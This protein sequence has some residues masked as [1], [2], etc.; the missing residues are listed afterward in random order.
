MKT[1][2]VNFYAGPGAGKTTGAWELA[3]Q[4][5]K[6]DVNV[7][8]VPEY[9]KE[10][11]W[12]E[13]WDLL[14]G[15]I[16]GQRNIFD[17]QRRRVDSIYGKVDVIVTDCP[18]TLSAV[19]LKEANSEFTKEVLKVY[20]QF[21]NF[22]LFIRRDENHFQQAGRIQNLEESK[23]IDNR[24]RQFLKQHDIFFCEYD[25]GAIQRIAKNVIYSREHNKHFKDPKAMEQMNRS[26]I[27]ERL[28]SNKTL[29]ANEKTP[30]SD[31]ISE[32]YR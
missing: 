8:Y 23:A 16:S 28:D 11:V 1:V 27:A 13:K 31:D 24:V 2:V 30:N 15:S 14:D 21:N 5:K 20:S 17:E 18:I 7:E 10:L 29:I 25:R 19:Y 22:N 32:R 3:A 4:L 9:A 6:M 12:A 26:S